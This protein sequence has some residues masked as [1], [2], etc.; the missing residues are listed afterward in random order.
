MDTNTLIDSSGNKPLHVSKLGDGGI[1]LGME[2]AIVGMCV[3]DTIE[4]EIESAQGFFEKGKTFQ[5]RP[6][7][8]GVK[9]KYHIEL[10]HIANQGN[11]FQK[12][13]YL[14]L[15]GVL[16][17][18]FGLSVLCWKRFS[19]SNGGS[20]GKTQTLRRKTEDRVVTGGPSLR[21]GTQ[22]RRKNTRK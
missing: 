11:A 16:V 2:L 12:T 3:G 1:L 13:E 21:Q 4:V 15:F 6:V 10:I 9:I 14:M 22:N 5:K 8:Q 17:L 7:P 20:G 19:S 18:V